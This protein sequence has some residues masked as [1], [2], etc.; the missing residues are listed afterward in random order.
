M[1]IKD[2]DSV[3]FCGFVPVSIFLTDVYVVLNVFRVKRLIDNFLHSAV[4]FKGFTSAELWR[5]S[6]LDISVAVVVINVNLISVIGS[7][8]VDGALALPD[9]IE[10]CAHTC[11]SKQVKVLQCFAIVTQFVNS[12]NSLK[13][14]WDVHLGP[15][16]CV[17]LQHFKSL[18]DLWEEIL[19]E[20]GGIVEGQGIRGT[21]N[22]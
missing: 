12:S 5:S 18:L 10:R 19:E 4:R 3:V 21:G 15:V 7:I 2:V 20:G 11:D 17:V 6:I 14:L 22:H 9:M 8:L 16:T 1:W 13:L